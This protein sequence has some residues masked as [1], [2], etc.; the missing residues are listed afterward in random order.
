MMC[1][2]SLTWT[3]CYYPSNVIMYVRMRHGKT[4]NEIVFKKIFKL[5]CETIITLL[6]N[7][8][9]IWAK[10]QKICFLWNLDNTTIRILAAPSIFG[11]VSATSSPPLSR[12]FPPLAV[13]Q[14]SRTY[15]GF[16]A[17]QL[18]QCNRFVYLQRLGYNA[19][20]WR[21]KCIIVGS[22][23]MKLHCLGSAT[24]YLYDHFAYFRRLCCRHNTALLRRQCNNLCILA[25]TLPPL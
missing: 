15:C 21:W 18:Q 12:R 10:A 22:S 20:L 17:S 19:A 25:A 23:I 7:N 1:C 8:Q 13:Q 16:A 11:V 6:V 3:D 9:L 14:H 4:V 2:C 5:E 24:P